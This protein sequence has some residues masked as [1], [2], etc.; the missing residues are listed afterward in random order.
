MPY[1]IEH[2]SGSSTVATCTS[3]LCLFVAIIL[4]FL[5]YRSKG[6]E[7]DSGVAAGLFGGQIPEPPRHL[8]ATR[9]GDVS[10]ESIES[11]KKDFRRRLRLTQ[12]ELEQMILEDSASRV[13]VLAVAS[14]PDV[15]LVWDWPEDQRKA[16]SLLGYT[17]KSI[18]VHNRSGQYIYNVTID[19][20]KLER[21][22]TFDAINEIAPGKEHVALGRWNGKSSL[23]TNYIY[24]FGREQDERVLLE[25]GWI[26]KKLHPGIS[27]VVIKIPMVIGYVAGGSYWKCEFEFN[28]DP[29]DESCFVRKLGY[30]L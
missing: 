21:E 8:P 28:Y 12:L 7:G 3:A 11:L 10:A 23:T 19:P 26:Q 29:G 30:K 15:A 5:G 16:K 4:L 6:E 14:E 17:E 18:L 22:L 2:L 1:L 13:S 24:F 9:T 27:D 20:I 25:R